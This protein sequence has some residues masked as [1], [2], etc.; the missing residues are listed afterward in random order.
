MCSALKHTILGTSVYRNYRSLLTTSFLTE[1]GHSCVC[2]VTNRADC[3]EMTVSIQSQCWQ[4]TGKT[5][6][7]TQPR[8]S[9]CHFESRSRSNLAISEFPLHLFQTFLLTPVQWQPLHNMKLQTKLSNTKY[10]YAPAVTTAR[11]SKYF[12]G[13]GTKSL[14]K[15]N[16]LRGLS[17]R[18]YYTD[19]TTAAC[20]WSDCQLLRIEG[21]TWSAWR[22]P[23]AVFSVF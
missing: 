9:E 18:E 20:R 17:L 3:V 2:I 7:W 8:T 1:S 10:P 16:K 21:V 12:L 23:T 5:R 22:I 11:L 19:L 4:E 15:Q 14:N 6:P 13:K